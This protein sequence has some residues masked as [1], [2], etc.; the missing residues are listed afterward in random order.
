LHCCTILA[1]LPEG[2]ALPAARLAEFHGVPAHYL[3]KH[4][5]ALA[6]AG[7]LD[8]VAG[9]RGGYRLG[10]RPADITLLDVVL[11]VDGDEPA[12]HCSEI[13]RRGPAAQRAS[14]YGAPCAIAAAMWQAEDA[15]RASLRAQT[16]AD[17]VAH[18]ATA[19]TPDAVAKTAAWLQEVLH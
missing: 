15:W 16:I 4:L 10:R 6:A 18:L 7:I 2:T 3:A 5:Q 9:R 11:A 17:V 14:T 12:F 13:R 8:P 1:V 19:A